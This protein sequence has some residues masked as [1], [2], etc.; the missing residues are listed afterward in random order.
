MIYICIRETVDWE[1]ELDIKPL[2]LRHGIA[3]KWFGAKEDQVFKINGQL[4]VMN[5][6]LASQAT[7]G[8]CR[9]FW[10]KSSISRSSLIRKSRKY[11]AL[12]IKPVD[13]GHSWCLPYVRMMANLMDDLKICARSPTR[14]L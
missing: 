9:G 6:A 1:K 5:R 8:V 13:P 12:Y 10:A 14:K 7:L 2:M 3:S 11:K 4:S